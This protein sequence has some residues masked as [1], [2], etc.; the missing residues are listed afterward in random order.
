MGGCDGARPGRNYYTE[1]VKLTPS[2]SIVLTLACGKYR[3]ND[4]DLG[5]KLISGIE[6]GTAETPYV[7]DKEFTIVRNGY[8]VTFT[9]VEYAKDT[10]RASYL[11][12]TVKK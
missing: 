7:I 3:F 12:M 8:T 2:D 11:K 1:F 6:L 5:I 4:L 9:N 10:T